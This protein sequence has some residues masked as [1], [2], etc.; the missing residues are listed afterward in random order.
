MRA[1]QLT[2]PQPVEE[3]PLRLVDIPIPQPKPDEVLVKVLACGV[4]QC[5]VPA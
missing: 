4:S 2:K 3:R 1:M 5:W